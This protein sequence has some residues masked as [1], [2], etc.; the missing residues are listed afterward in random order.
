[1]QLMTDSLAKTIPPLYA[2]DGKGNNAIVY[3]HYF[4]PYNGWDW[5]MTEYD[6]DTKEGF[7]LVKGW[8]D[9]LGYFSIAEFEQINNSKGFPLIERD[10]YWTPCRLG[11]VR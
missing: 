5:Y 7:G 2:Q 8:D 3:A 10:L 1:M 11:D 9:E 4:C 6:P